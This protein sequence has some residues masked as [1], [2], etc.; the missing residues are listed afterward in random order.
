MKFLLLS[1]ATLFAASQASED[2]MN[3]R[4][5]AEASAAVTRDLHEKFE[6]LRDEVHKDRSALFLDPA[7]VCARFEAAFSDQVTCD[8]AFNWLAL[9]F[10]FVCTGA[11][12]ADFGGVVSGIPE[13]GGFIDLNVLSF[14]V[15]VGGGVCLDGAVVGATPVGSFCVDATVAGGRGGSGLKSC[16]AIVGPLACPCEACTSGPGVSITCGIIPEVCIPIPFINT[17]RPARN[18]IAPM[19]IEGGK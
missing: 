19:A 5:N 16:Q 4:V 15:D 18:S 12:P 1:L 2:Q 8:C 3:L 11:F 9:S 13:Y 17:L 10:G 7:A 14:N 6:S